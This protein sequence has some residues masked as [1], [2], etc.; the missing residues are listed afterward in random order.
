MEYVAAPDREVNS[1]DLFLNLP[2][3]PDDRETLIV[4][5]G[6]YCYAVL[7]RFPYNAG[8]MLVVPFRKV[9]QPAELTSAERTDFFDTIIR[10]Q[11]L[12]TTA[13]NPDGFNIG[14]NLGKAA[15]AGIPE[16]LHCHIVPR[17]SGDTNFMPVTGKTRVLPTA[18]DSMWERLKSCL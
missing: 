1:R 14:I 3:N 10:I 13:L 15:G 18:L 16:H 11:E 9:A 6:S 2:Q 5:R 4:L 12:L 8:H 7:N 17:W